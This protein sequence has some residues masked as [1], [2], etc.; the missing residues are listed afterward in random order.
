MPDLSEEVEAQTALHATCTTT[1][2]RRVALGD[3]C[4][5]QTADLPFLVK[6]HL[7]VLASVDDASDV[8]DSD[9]SLCNIGGLDLILLWKDEGGAPYPVTKTRLG[10]ELSDCVDGD[11][12]ARRVSSDRHPEDKAGLDAVVRREGAL[13]SRATV[14]VSGI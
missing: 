5:D 10:L 9:A 13:G 11:A 2:L 3:E 1:P 4:F 7:A 12:V 8:R 6:A 14:T